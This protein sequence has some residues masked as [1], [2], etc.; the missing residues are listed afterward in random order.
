MALSTRNIADNASF[1][2]F[3]N[4]YLREIDP[5]VWHSSDNWRK[6]TG[7]TYDNNENLVL[8]LQL[9]G[10]NSTLAIGASYYSLA[11]RHT[12][13]DIFQKQQN[14]WSWEPLDKMSAILLLTNNIYACHSDSNNMS[15]DQLEL[16]SRI[17]ESHQ[18][19]HHYL[20]QREN[21]HQ[22]LSNNF[23]DSE[24][25]LLFGHWLHPTPKSRQGMHAWQHQ[26]YAPE[27]KARFQL[28]FFA[29]DRHLIR[30]GSILE[31]SAEDIVQQILNLDTNQ[32]RTGQTVSDSVPGKVLI[33]VH[34][35]QAQWLLHQE[36]IQQLIADNTLNDLGPMGASFT[37]TSSV[38]TLYCEELDYMVKLSIPVKITNSLRNNM[39]HELNAGLYV[40]N[41][42]R[43]SNF[44][45]E[46]PTFA[47]IGDP[48]YMTVTLDDRQESGF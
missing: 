44:S 45:D 36:Y 3:M 29:V 23:I 21:D 31:Q 18:I 34:P 15:C 10:L 28:H 32:N 27:L 24:Q 16:V 8:E 38:R 1:Q 22:L 43:N 39:A 12:L 13:T 11:G 4:A 9:T 48:A 7:L 20:Q 40:S 2:A 14:Q 46:C 6:Q 42:I 37:P 47:I 26:N 25:S 30:Q 17:I 33:P 35:L 5:G 19:M 41:L